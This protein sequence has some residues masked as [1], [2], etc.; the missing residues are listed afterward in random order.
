MRFHPPLPCRDH[1]YAAAVPL[2]TAPRNR[3]P[4]RLLFFAASAALAPGSGA[5]F[6]TGKRPRTVLASARGDVRVTARMTDI[7]R[8]FPRMAEART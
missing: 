5:I 2:P 1:I 7:G 4:P 6:A 8:R 3:G